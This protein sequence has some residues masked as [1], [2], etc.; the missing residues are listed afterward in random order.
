[1]HF[2]VC[3]VFATLLA[4]SCA[5]P[6]EEAASLLPEQDPRVGDRVSRI[7]FRP[8]IRGFEE[9]DAGRGLLLNQGSR[10]FL[11]TFGGRCREAD[12]AIAIGF[13]RSFAQA[14]CLRE[15]DALYFSETISPTR[16]GADV[17]F[18]PIRRIYAFD[19][20]VPFEAPE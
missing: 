2:K 6:E 11:V 16:S 15:G 10:Q 9:W 4:V 20:S 5:L 3:A 14:G 19:D 8:S 7:C 12:R 13:S 1:M 18:C 17:G